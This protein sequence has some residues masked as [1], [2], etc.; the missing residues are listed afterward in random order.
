MSGP[1][2]ENGVEIDHGGPVDMVVDVPGSKSIANRALVLA[3]L[4][5][6]ESVLTNVPPGDDVEAMTTAL[7]SLGLEVRGG[8]GS[9]AVA[10][11]LDLEQSGNI[12]LDARLAGTT[13]RFLIAL[14]A[15]RSGHTTVIGEGRLRERPFGEL[16]DALRHLGASV[17]G[18]PGLPITASRGALRGGT[19]QMTGAVSSQFVSALMMIGPRLDG[20][21][22]IELTGDVVSASYVAMTASLMSR[23]GASVEFDGRTVRVTEGRYRAATI[24]VEPDAS[25][26]SYPA[27]L[28]AVA[29][30]VVRIKR[31]ATIALQSDRVI[32][33]ILGQMGAEVR[34][35][36]DDMVIQKDPVQAL[37]A[38]DVDLR[39]SSDL[40]PT[41]A[42][43]AAVADGRTRIRGVGFVRNKESDRI[44]DLAAELRKFGIDVIEDADGLDVIG[45][46]VGPAVIDPHHDHRLAMALAL[47]GRIG[48]G[49][50]LIDP[51]VVSKSWP[52]YLT[53]LGLVP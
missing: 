32:F 37:H 4:A 9:L 8:G 40:V 3:A 20:G 12:D 47:L 41:V 46:S 39:D 25:S 7:R 38:I 2:S 29:G 26:A 15:L 48:A 49:T 24:D 17:Q 33:D 52:G 21:L 5:D 18:G 13:S 42:A 10:Q 34:A 43:L 22:R 45:G 30:G 16:V 51:T 36:G 31:A 53:D 11:A 6:G 35:A 50:K 28:A 19:V 1:H 44:G 27:A 14:A 23:F